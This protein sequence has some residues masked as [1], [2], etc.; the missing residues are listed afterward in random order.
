MY[1]VHKTKMQV[2][3]APSLEGCCAK[4]GYGGGWEQRC[5]LLLEGQVV[6]KVSQQ[7]AVWISNAERR[8]PGEGRAGRTSPREQRVEVHRGLLRNRCAFLWLGQRQQA[9]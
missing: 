4:W 3:E 6:R 8:E 7:R 9:E 2:A 5:R 1:H